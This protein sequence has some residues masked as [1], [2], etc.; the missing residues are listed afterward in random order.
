MIY[1]SGSQ[2]TMEVQLKRENEHI[3]PDVIAPFFPLVRM[4]HANAGTYIVLLLYMVQNL[5]GNFD[6]F[7]KF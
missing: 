3:A 1:S 5:W 4:F 2:V 7:C 6:K